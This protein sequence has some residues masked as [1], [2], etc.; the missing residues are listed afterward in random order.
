MGSSKYL[1]VGFLIGMAVGAFVFYSLSTFSQ[2]S[3]L[4]TQINELQS[5]N[6]QLRANQPLPSATPT[7]KPILTPTLSATSD[8]TIEKTGKAIQIQSIS[9]PSTG[10]QAFT[11]YVQNVGDSDLLLSNTN[12]VFINGVAATGAWTATTLATGN[13]ASYVA[14]SSATLPAGVQSIT[15]KVTTTDGTFS[16]ITEQFTIK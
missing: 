6:A 9:Y 3:T 10:G 7:I 15:F 14:T 1:I 13:T 5:E 16:Q 4:Q 8:S 12:S 11:L 2:I